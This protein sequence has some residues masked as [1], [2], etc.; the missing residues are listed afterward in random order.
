MAAPVQA[1]LAAQGDTTGLRGVIVELRGVDDSGSYLRYDYI[2]RNP[3]GSS[4][5]IAVVRVD[6]TASR[7]TGAKTL[8]ATGG[9]RHLA[10]GGASAI[11][12]VPAG[13]VSP[14]NWEA[15]LIS[16]SRV[17]RAI[18]QWHGT[19]GGLHDRDSIAPGATLSGLGIRSTYLPGIRF[20]WAYPTWQSCCSR[21]RPPQPDVPPEEH[22]GP[23]EF[24]VKGLTVGPTLHPDSVS[25]QVLQAFRGRTC[26]ELRWV[27]DAGVCASLAASLG[28]ARQALT[29]ADTTGA[30]TEL[31][32]FVSELE[33][34]HGAGR[35]V[36]DNAYWLLKVNAEFLLRRL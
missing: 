14:S 19:R 15:Y 20:V 2:V 4:W 12:H 36:S 26:T 32:S 27:T 34:Q 3:T 9:F 29:Q 18:L 13:P 1:S 25:I 31:R 23:E 35:P 21:P 30:R 16:S 17:S 28:R 5:A 7:G 8:P 11:D 6:L 33:V 10:G 24:Q 22:P